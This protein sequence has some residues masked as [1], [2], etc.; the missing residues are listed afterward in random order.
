LNEGE[1]HGQEGQAKESREEDC[2]EGRQE[3]SEESCDAGKHTLLLQHD[4]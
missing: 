4:G 3:A 1:G 2:Q